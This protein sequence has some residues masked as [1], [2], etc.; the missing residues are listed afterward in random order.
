MHILYV[1]SYLSREDT[2]QG[3]WGRK[4]VEE[5]RNTGVEVTTVPRYDESDGR[6]PR[7]TSGF[8]RISSLKEDLPGWLVHLLIEPRMVIRGLSYT[9]ALWFQARRSARSNMP[10]VVY[11]RVG[12]WDWAPWLIGRSLKR[13]VVMEVHGLNYLERTFRGQRRSRLLRAFELVQLRRAACLRVCSKSLIRLLEEEGVD[14]HRI[15][16]IPLGVEVMPRT[17]SELQ[18]PADPVKMA[19]SMQF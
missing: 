11:A 4:F 7:L 12:Y 1:N 10:D 17:K 9:V 19:S 2:E 3:T 15:R 16:F 18:V 14:S 8:F 13:P 5:L 6:H